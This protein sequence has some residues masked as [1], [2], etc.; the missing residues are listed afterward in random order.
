MD[1]KVQWGDPV[2]AG[3]AGRDPL[4]E[5]VPKVFLTESLLIHSF[6]YWLDCF[7][8]LDTYKQS[9]VAILND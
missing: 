4:D 2:L 8:L 9:T 3:Q 7:Q 6:A 5:L 1:C